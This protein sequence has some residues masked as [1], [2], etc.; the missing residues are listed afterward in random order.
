MTYCLQ[1]LQVEYS[2]TSMATSV[3]ARQYQYA[4]T[5]GDMMATTNAGLAEGQRS[6]GGF[7]G[8][9]DYHVDALIQACEKPVVDEGMMTGVKERALVPFFGTD[10]LV[11]GMGSALDWPV[12]GNQKKQRGY[13]NGNRGGYYA[14]QQQDNGGKGGKKKGGEGNKGGARQYSQKQKSGSSSPK[15]KYAG[16]AFTLSPVPESVPKPTFIL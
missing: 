16:P 3:V 11:G 9:R 10:D 6:Q 5:R 4:T 7:K 12:G 13:G 14:S 1:L 15:E 8:D 2:R